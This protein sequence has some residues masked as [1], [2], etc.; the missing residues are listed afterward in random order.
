[1]DI[2]DIPILPCISIGPGSYK[3]WDVSDFILEEIQKVSLE[4]INGNNRCMAKV[5]F[6]VRGEVAKLLFIENGWF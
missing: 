5:P 6:R 3:W 4:T 1:V 2:V